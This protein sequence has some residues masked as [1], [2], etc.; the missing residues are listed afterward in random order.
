MHRSPAIAAA[1]VCLVL[2]ARSNGASHAGAL[3]A[4]ASCGSGG[5]ISFSWTFYEDPLNPTGHPEWVGYDVWR[6]SLADC[7]AFVRVNAAPFP[8]AGTTESLTYTEVP[9]AS[10]TTFQYQVR[11]VDANRQQLF[12]DAIA[13]DCIAHDAWASCPQMSVPL[14]QGTLQDL[15]WALLVQPCAPGCYQSFYFDDPQ[16]V[17]LLRPFA[18]TGTAFS[19]FGQ[20]VCGTVE[21]CVI[22]V[23]HY[24][25]VPCG[26]T[27]AQ[28][29]TWGRVKSIY[30]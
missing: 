23:D 18:G 3:S 8:R 24:E 21:G 14:T 4:D 17:S 10:G 30:R 13:C 9:P 12:L 5:I 25:T 27:P 29:A 11:L 19:F 15:G 28:R 1:I 2:I 22:H 16:L 26:P 20:A 7:G 6:R